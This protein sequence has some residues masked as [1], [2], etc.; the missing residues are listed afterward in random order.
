[1]S[2]SK[3]TSFF[4]EIFIYEKKS[5]NKGEVWWAVNTIALNFLMELDFTDSSMLVLER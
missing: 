1:M 2:R 4:W 5:W 3:F